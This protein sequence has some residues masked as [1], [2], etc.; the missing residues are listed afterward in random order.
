[1]KPNLLKNTAKNLPYLK[2]VTQQRDKLRARVKALE[3]EQ[4]RLAA[5]VKHLSGAWVTY[6]PELLPTPKE[7]RAEGIHVLEDWFGW[8]QEW[9]ILLR[10]YGRLTRDSTVL[11]IGCGLGRTAFALRNHLSGCGSYQGLDPCLD[12]IL[13]LKSAFQRTHPNFHFVWA[14]VKNAWCNSQSSL[15]TDQYKFDYADNSFD[16]VYSASTFISIKPETAQNYLEQSA[17]VLRPGGR[18][19]LGVFLLDFYDKNRPRPLGFNR[20]E[21]NFDHLCPPYGKDLAVSDPDCPEPLT[22]YRQHLIERLVRRAGLELIKV[23]LPGLWSGHTPGWFGT[24]DLIV[25]SKPESRL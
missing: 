12:R 22:A 1:M 19:L 23:P 25:L 18:C 9:S 13:R 8:G 16:I 3:A 21:L 14:D 11:E 20:P 2:R 7:M 15:P 5:Q 17:R 24:Y 4:K 6:E 10:I